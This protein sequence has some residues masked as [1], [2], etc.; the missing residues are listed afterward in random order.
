MAAKYS[1]SK[2]K[3][4]AIEPQANHRRIMTSAYFLCMCMHFCNSENAFSLALILDVCERAREQTDERASERAGGRSAPLNAHTRC[5]L[6][7]LNVQCALR[8]V[9]FVC[10]LR[11]LIADAGSSYLYAMHKST[12]KTERLVESAVYVRRHHLSFVRLIAI[13]GRVR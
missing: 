1:K 13:N 2:S 3:S 6:M 10:C 8:I 9:T 5:A 11:I 12:M 4:N 7:C